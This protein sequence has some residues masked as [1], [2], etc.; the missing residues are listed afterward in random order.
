M[1]LALAPPPR[2]VYF[3]GYGLGGGTERA[4]PISQRSF[5]TGLFRAISGKRP[6][7]RPG[8]DTCRRAPT[9]PV[10]SPGKR[11][12]QEVAEAAGIG[13]CGGSAQFASGVLLLISQVRCASIA[14][15]GSGSDS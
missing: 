8:R 3:R 4:I 2:A 13:A 11:K 5:A 15:R 10:H 14:A 9:E 6:G 7:S 12:C 1:L